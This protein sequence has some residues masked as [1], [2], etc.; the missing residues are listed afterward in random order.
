MPDIGL[1]V[2]PSLCRI[3]SVSDPCS[4]ATCS[5]HRLDVCHPVCR[6]SLVCKQRLSTCQSSLIKWTV[7][8]S[9][10]SWTDARLA[11][12]PPLSRLSFHF[13][14]QLWGFSWREGAA[15]WCHGED[16]VFRA[17][18]GDCANWYRVFHIG[19]PPPFGSFLIW[20][21]T[22]RVVV[23]FLALDGIQIFG[24]LCC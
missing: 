13:F 3:Q 2:G 15:W 14:T 9:L 21:S 19:D 22:F 24:A 8:E 20:F 17:S 18:F 5:S 16:H 12:D 23:F 11:A 4:R 7:R 6:V 10:S 1:T